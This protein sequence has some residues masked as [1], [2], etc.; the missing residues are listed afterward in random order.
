MGFFLAISLWGLAV[1]GMAYN[2]GQ[3]SVEPEQ[4]FIDLGEVR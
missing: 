3:E 4:V 1:G 2:A